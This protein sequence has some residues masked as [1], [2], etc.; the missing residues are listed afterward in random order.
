MF[1]SVD[2]ALIAV[3][4]GV[5]YLLN[6]FTPLDWVVDQGSISAVV[7]IVGPLLVYF[8]PNREG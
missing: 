8:I 1:T 5:I 3:A 7:S 6:L 4:M 2:K